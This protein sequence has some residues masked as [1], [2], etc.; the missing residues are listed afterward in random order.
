MNHSFPGPHKALRLLWAALLAISMLLFMLLSLNTL[1]PLKRQF[2]SWRLSPHLK[3]TKES[4]AEGTI[5]SYIN[6]RGKVVTAL[7]KNYATVIKTY[8]QDGNCILERYYDE[9]GKPAVLT[10]GNSA[11]R[12]EYNA[13]GQWIFSQYLDAQLKPMVSRVGYCSV[14][15]TYTNSG[16]TASYMYYDADDLPTLDLSGRYGVRYEYNANLKVSAAISLDAAGNPM[17]NM[18]HFAIC[19]MTYS[20]EGK[21]LTERFYDENSEPCRL[22]SGQYGYLYSNGKP[23]CL[24]RD[25][26]RMFVLRHFLLNSMPAVLGIGVLLLVLILLSGHALNLLLLLAY[27]AF[28]GYMTFMNREVGSSIVTWRVP[29]N[30]Y[31][32]FANKEI[33]ANIWLFIPLGAILYKLSH[34][35]EIAVLP[36]VL[37]LFIETFQ[38]F[39]DIGAFEISDL[40]ANSLGGVIGVIG[41]YLFEPLALRIWNKLRTRFQ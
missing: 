34:M 12:R 20:P 19:R 15:Q 39:F 17:N 5:T 16:K 7:D 28:I 14:R 2:P 27:L 38:L 4:T 31:L 33:L 6:N 10:Y 13:D 1:L 8:D 3:T 24:D 30:Y 35:W 32:F 18:D 40:V 29:P 36:V 23:V 9:H 11:L 26:N 21:L 41:C 37:S 22:S 25:G